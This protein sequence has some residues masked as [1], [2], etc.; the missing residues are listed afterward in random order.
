VVSL[1]DYEDFAR[2]FT[3]IGKAHAALLNLKAGRTIFITVAAEDG[4]PILAANPVLLRLV[5][6]LRNSGDPLVRFEVQ[7]HR[8]A[9][10][11]VRLRVKRDHAYSR[12]T[13]SA[14]V[15]EALHTAFSFDTRE[16]GQPVSRSEVIAVA[17]GVPGVVAVDLEHF[18]RRGA[19]RLA[20]RI[21]AEGPRADGAGNG[22]AAELLTLAPGPLEWLGEMP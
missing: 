5:G 20:T 1:R 14:A 18:Y 4:T 13:V 17:D 21:S 7:P 19:R 15:D 11:N 3:G 6:A 22:I 12:E 16:F 2:A 9:L 8:E 10:F